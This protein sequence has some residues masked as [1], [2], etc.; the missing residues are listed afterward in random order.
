MGP[1]KFKNGEKVAYEDQKGPVI[2]KTKAIKPRDQRTL[3]R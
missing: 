1:T 2:H 3:T